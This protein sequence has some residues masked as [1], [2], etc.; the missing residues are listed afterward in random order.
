[1]L[2]YHCGKAHD[3]LGIDEDYLDRKKLNVSMINYIGMI[4]NGFSE[5]IVSPLA[6]PV[7]DHLFTV[8]EEGHDQSLSK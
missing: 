3:Y 2:T 8:R 5:Q 1:M 4:F 7:T 6:D